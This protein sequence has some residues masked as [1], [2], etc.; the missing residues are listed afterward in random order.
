MGGDRLLKERL[1]SRIRES[2]DDG[3]RGRRSTMKKYEN[4]SSVISRGG[5][6]RK[7]C[8]ISSLSVGGGL[9]PE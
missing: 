4:K 8:E 2:D 6:G 3:R 5:S 9:K 7:I 1:R